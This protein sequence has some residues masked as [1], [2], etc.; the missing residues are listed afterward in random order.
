MLIKMIIFNTRL[1]KN[2]KINKKS[3]NYPD[4]FNFQ[5]EYAIK[6]INLISEKEDKL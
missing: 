2:P 4:K 6:E 1:C 5:I 3:M